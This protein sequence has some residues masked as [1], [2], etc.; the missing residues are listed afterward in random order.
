MG[1]RCGKCGTTYTKWGGEHKT[2]TRLKARDIGWE[3]V[4][5]ERATRQLGIGC[6]LQQA[7]TAGD[8]CEVHLRP[9]TKVGETRLRICKGHNHRSQGSLKQ[10]MKSYS[11]Q[12]EARLVAY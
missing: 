7:Y 6:S 5:E 8:K 11:R 12:L 10:F 2:E 1:G 4:L 9:H 3:W